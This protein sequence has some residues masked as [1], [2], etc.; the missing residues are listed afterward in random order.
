MNQ[1]GVHVLHGEADRLLEVLDEARMVA[2]GGITELLCGVVINRFAVRSESLPLPGLGLFL[3]EPIVEH[4]AADVRSHAQSGL[5]R[6]PGESLGILH[7]L[8]LGLKP[9]PF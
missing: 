9:A 7:A 8:A 3:E 5:M 2:H 1:I 4:R 6:E